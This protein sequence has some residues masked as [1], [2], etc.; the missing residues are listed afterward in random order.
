MK[1]E[2]TGELKEIDIKNHICFHFS[3]TKRAWDRYTDIDFS[4][5]WL[6]KKLYKEKYE[7]ILVYVISYKT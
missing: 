7:N 3:D 4:G 2:S 6:D 1:M 5:I